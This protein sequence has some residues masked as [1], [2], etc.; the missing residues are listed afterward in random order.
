MVERSP[1]QLTLRQLFTEAERLTRELTEH[2]EQGF[3]PKL[4]NL[5]RLTDPGHVDVHGNP[6]EDVSLRNCA[7]QVLESELYTERLYEKIET[8][9][10]A[11]DGDVARIIAE[12]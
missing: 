8:Y 5:A 2:L 4:Q 1:E 12:A 10:T 11:I 3:L 6:A 9:C 7:A